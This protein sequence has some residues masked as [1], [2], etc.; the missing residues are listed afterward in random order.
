MKTN[1]INLE[2]NEMR[3]ED[4]RTLAKEYGM[5]GAWKAKK[6]EMIEFLEAIKE[7][8]IK[9]QQNSSKPR[10]NSKGRTR[11]I[12]V[13]KDGELVIEIEG[14]INTFKWADENKVCNAGW[15]K[16]SLKTGK[17]TVA[18]RKYKQGGYLFKYSN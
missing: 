15:V 6:S 9:E 18:G 5:V 7:A 8:Q 17:E 2:L 13:L 14:L 11:T 3:A 16:H 1:L 12:Q 4:L 10:R